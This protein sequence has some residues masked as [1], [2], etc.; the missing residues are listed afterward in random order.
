[1]LTKLK[2]FSAISLIIG[3]FAV[4]LFGVTAYSVYDTVSNNT[5]FKRIVV[6][7]E[8][9]DQMRDAAYNI[10]AVMA[11]TNG[12]MLQAALGNPVSENVAK[13]TVNVVKLARRNMD[14]FMASPFN[15]PE[16]SRLAAE[17][18]AAFNEVYKVAEIKLGYLHNPAG[19]SGSLEHDMELRTAL[20]NKVDQYTDASARMSES[21]IHA[22]ERGY[23]IML[24]VGIVVLILAVGLLLA[25]RYWL[26]H[27]LVRRMET[28]VE[29]L[30]RVAAGDLSQ[31]IDTGSQNEIGHMLTELETMRTS[32]TSTILGIRD[33]VQRI[34]ANAQEIAHGNNDLSSR[35][36]EQAAALQETA[37]S[38][39][40]I[41]TTVR[42]NA[43]N[44]HAARQLAESASHNAHNGGEVMQSL[45]Q[46]MAEITTS[47]RQIADI[48]GVIDSI[49][50]QTNILALNAAVEAARAGEQGR[51]FAV[52][53]EEVRNLAK[54]SAD[55]AKEISQLINTSVNNIDIG[56]RQ[57]GQASTVMQEI[58]TSVAQVTQIMGEITSAS[59]EQSAGINQI[60]QAVNEMDLVTQQNAAMVEEA[61][62]AAGELEAQS[63]ALEKLVAQ[64]RLNHESAM[65]KV[66]VEVNKPQRQKEPDLA[67][68]ETF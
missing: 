49:A 21:Y 48:N 11:N 56:S 5:N 25:V 62:M 45:E 38:M 51:G 18:N 16:E 15:T 32:L 30:R 61:A 41:K 66:P 13:H 4:M 54:R 34:H 1:M 24:G 52:V 28:T 20:R 39:E 65:A 29:M 57:V 53:A 37:A 9:N 50:N 47:S 36:E 63:D 12:L 22:S 68:W 7:S 43:D 42:Q 3:L 19:Y 23:Q 10:S 44:A 55:A 14:A 67:Q 31:P 46:I 59:D 58:V 6:A 33:S 40:E 64:F 60:S 35:T 2:I 27:T 17:V 26:R 8:N